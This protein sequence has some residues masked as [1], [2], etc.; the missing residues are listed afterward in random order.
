MESPVRTLQVSFGKYAGR[1]NKNCQ[2]T[3]GEIIRRHPLSNSHPER[4]RS[5][6]N[7]VDLRKRSVP[8][9]RISAEKVM[10]S[11]I[12]FLKEIRGVG[13]QLTQ[14]SVSLHKTTL[15]LRELNSTIQSGIASSN[16][17]ATAM[18]ALTF[19][20]GAFAA[21]QVVVAYLSYTSDQ[22]IIEAKSSCYKSVLTTSDIDLNYKSC[23]RSKGLSD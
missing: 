13:S 21:A 22:G 5:V 8:T 4:W 15:I 9:S 10:L 6:Q 20:L 7:G 3:C 16:K 18:F 19:A 12:E 11:E 23:L 2:R 17:S 14:L 1:S